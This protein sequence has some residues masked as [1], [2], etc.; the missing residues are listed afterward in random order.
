MF[1]AHGFLRRIFEIFDRFETPVDMI[2][3]SEVSVSLTVDN[4]DR[5]DEIQAELAVFSEVTAESGQAIVCLVGENI[6]YT[7]G[8]ASRVFTALNGVNI[9]M[10]S[11]GASLLNLGVVIAMKDLSAAVEAL[12]TEFFSELDPEVFD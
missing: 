3:T 10:I 2:S 8:V 5:L 12:H 11:Q 9:R 6:R 7:P 4:T 1:M